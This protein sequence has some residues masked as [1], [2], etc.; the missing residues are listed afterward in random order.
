MTTAA[1][2]CKQPFTDYDS[3]GTQRLAISAAG[4]MI[5]NGQGY[6]AQ[7]SGTNNVVIGNGEGIVQPGSITSRGVGT[8]LG[9][10]INSGTGAPNYVAAVGDTWIRTDTPTTANQ[11]IYMCNSTAG[12][13]GAWT[14]IA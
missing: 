1:G 4:A 2:Q 14:G 8:G 3:S 7:T 12:G 6:L 9:S 5:I 13:S 11:R 10:K